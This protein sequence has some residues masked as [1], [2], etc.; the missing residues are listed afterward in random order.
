MV[1]FYTEEELALC[2]AWKAKIKLCNRYIDEIYEDVKKPWVNDHLN[3]SE[4]YKLFLKH[5][6][7]YKKCKQHIA[8]RVKTEVFAACSPAET[9]AYDKKVVS[10]YVWQVRPML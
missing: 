8:G 4:K 1:G 5:Y 9:P 6:A 10:T 3:E 2:K 7:N